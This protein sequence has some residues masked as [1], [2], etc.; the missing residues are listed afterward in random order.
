MPKLK[1]ARSEW[2]AIPNILGYIRILLIPLFVWKYLSAQTNLDYYIAAGIIVLSSLTDMLDG[3][4]A[5]KFN[6][7]TDL[8]KILDPIADKLTLCAILICFSLKFDAIF[9]MLLLLFLVKEITMGLLTILL[10]KKHGKKLNGAKWFGKFA[11]AVTDV[12]IVILL[13]FPQSMQHDIYSRYMIYTMIFIIGCVMLFAFI[14]YTK[15]LLGMLFDAIRNNK[16]N[17]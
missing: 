2:Y 15:V 9:Q 6:Q 11:T 4:I 17:R 10:F 3:K 1:I 14:M 8:G 5:R 12:L 16:K 7:I 13:L